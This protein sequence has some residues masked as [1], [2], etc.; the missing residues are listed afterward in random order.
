[1]GESADDHHGD[2]GG[3]GDELQN[4]GCFFGHFQLGQKQTGIQ[5]M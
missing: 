4:C 1:M 2:D 3:D 5:N